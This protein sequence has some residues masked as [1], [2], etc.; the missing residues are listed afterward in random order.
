MRPRAVSK[1]NTVAQIVLAATVLADL[2]YA[3]N[4]GD[5]RDGLVWLVAVF[6]VV[7]AGFYVIDWA[8]HMGGGPVAA[9]PA[10]GED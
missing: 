1:V 3:M 2:A 7:S 10:G 8:R 9:P 5:I 6:T 4:L